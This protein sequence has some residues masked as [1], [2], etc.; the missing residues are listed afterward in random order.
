[1]RGLLALL[2]LV[3]APSA[4]A[5]GAWQRG[6]GTA[7]SRA[8]VDAA[9]RDAD[10]VLLGETH[11]NPYHHAAQAALLRAMV[12]AG[13]R[14]AVV[15]EMVRRS[16]QPALDAWATGPAARDPDGFASA[17]DW[18]AEGWPDFALYRPIVQVAIDAGLAMVAGGLDA[19]PTRAV[20]G[21]GLAALDRDRRTAWGLAEPVSAAAREAHLDSVFDGHCR[22]VPREHLGRMVDVQVARDASMAAALVGHAGGAVLIAGRGHARADIGVPVFLRRL[23]PEARIVTVGLSEGEAA[24]TF[25][26]LHAF[27]APERADPCVALRERFSGTK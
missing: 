26:Y 5:E 22:L 7:V 12:E 23:A 17:A 24:G 6:D 21:A 20:A 27:P 1:M 13:R 2:I 8:A 3:F 19:E 14:P 25:D 18:A 9:L 10:F 15:W 16:R 4:G 11:D